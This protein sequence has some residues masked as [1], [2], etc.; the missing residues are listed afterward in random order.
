MFAISWGDV[1][2]LENL[3]YV[4]LPLPSVLVGLA[5][6][7]GSTAH[8][9]GVNRKVGEGGDALGDFLTLVVPSLFLSILGKWDGDD[10]VNVIEEVYSHTFLCQ[11]SPHVEGN[12]WA[13]GIF[14]LVEDVAGE[15]VS[16]V[17]EQGT[18]FL[19][20]N[21]VPKHLR[22]LVLVGI[23]PS[24]GARE[25]QVASHANGLFL[26]RKSIA[27]NGAEPREKQVYDFR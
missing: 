11:E 26:A 1:C 4:V 24:V 20:R 22:H 27:T 19:Y 12:F 25:V 18:G 6:D 7:K 2:Q 13:M 8:A 16:F 3:P 10:A 23:F 17:I 14:Q 9:I 15:G 5:F 21:L